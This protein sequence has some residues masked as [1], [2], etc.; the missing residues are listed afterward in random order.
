MLGASTFDSNWTRLPLAHS[1]LAAA[2]SAVTHIKRSSW[3]FS[4]VISP[5]AIA[6]PIILSTGPNGIR[7]A[8]VFGRSMRKLIREAQTAAY[9]T[10]IVPAVTAPEESTARR[11]Q[12]RN[13]R[14]QGDG[15]CGC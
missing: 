14:I 15:G 7:K 12:P 5:T 1:Q 3:R 9:K 8:S 6:I 11:K 2:I 13:E 10:I 4:P